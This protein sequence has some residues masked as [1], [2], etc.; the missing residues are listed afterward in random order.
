MDENEL[1][2]YF[3]D[4]SIREVLLLAKKSIML[5]IENRELEDKITKYAN[6]NEQDTKDY[7]ILYNKMENIEGYC[8]GIINTSNVNDNDKYIAENI[9]QFIRGED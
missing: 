8:K 3:K 9:L 2:D 5:T 6:I 4:L 7:A 1:L